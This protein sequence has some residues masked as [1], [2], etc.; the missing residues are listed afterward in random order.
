[1]FVDLERWLTD[2]A[3]P[4]AGRHPLPKPELFAEGM[5]SLGIS[6]DSVLVAYDDAS[7]T[8]AARLVWLLRITGH[9]A[10]ILDGGIEAWPGPLVTG[11]NQRERGHFQLERWPSDRLASSDDVAFASLVLDARAPER[12]RGEVEPI[13]RRAGHIPGARNAPTSSNLDEQGRF[14]PSHVL[15]EQYQNL[16]VATGSTPVLYCGSGVTAC[17]DLLALEHAGF[18]DGRLYA[19]SWSQWSADPARPIETGP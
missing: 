7:G 15:R 2:P 6:D 16:G 11:S 17:H 18:R 8:V 10:S 5:E 13:D 12:F 3:S 9:D 4:A 19:G 14:K 1:V